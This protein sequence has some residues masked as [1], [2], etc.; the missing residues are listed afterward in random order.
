MKQ[1]LF[2]VLFCMDDLCRSSFVQ[3]KIQHHVKILCVLKPQLDLSYCA[4]DAAESGTERNDAAVI[5]YNVYLPL[6]IS[7]LLEEVPCFCDVIEFH[8]CLLSMSFY[9]QYATLSFMLVWYYMLRF[10]ASDTMISLWAE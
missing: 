3:S 2:F 5:S 1:P 8:K 9:F 6:A 4:V 10:L 7:E